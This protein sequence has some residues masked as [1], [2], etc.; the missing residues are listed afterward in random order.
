LYQSYAHTRL[1]HVSQY[2]GGITYQ[3]EALPTNSVLL[4]FDLT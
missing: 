2:W 4:T 1:L 3:T